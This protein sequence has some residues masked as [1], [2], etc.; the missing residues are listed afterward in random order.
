M[1]DGPFRSLQMRKPWKEL[2]KRGDQETYDAAQVAEAA[3]VA[4]ASD[5]K[6]EVSPYLTQELKA[7]FEGRDNSLLMPDIALQQLEEMK[8]LAA[9][10]VFGKNAVLC[11]IELIDEGKFGADAFHEAIGLAAKMRGLAN[12][13]SVKEHFLRESNQQRAEHVHSRLSNA[14]CGLSEIQLG[15]RLSS[16]GVVEMRQ[17]GKMTG[18]EAGV[19]L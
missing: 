19:P 1:S 13:L 14:I 11:S 2:A 10:S 4:L 16:P 9:G 18:I 3:T 7:I 6:M 17:P 8:A 15:L 5:F 12:V